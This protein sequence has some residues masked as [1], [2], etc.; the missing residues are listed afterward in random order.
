MPSVKAQDVGFI[1][2]FLIGV[3][4]CYEIGGPKVTLALLVLVLLSQIYVKWEKIDSIIR[5][6]IK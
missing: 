2:V 4:A 1:A 3:L 6:F 5:G